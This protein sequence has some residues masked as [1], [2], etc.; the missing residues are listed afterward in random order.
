MPHRFYIYWSKSPSLTTPYNTLP[1]PP[2]H[3]Q[4]AQEIYNCL[5]SH[6][7]KVTSS[8]ALQELPYE[9]SL[10][11]RK[12][13][14]LPTSLPMSST[15][16]LVM[17]ALLPTFYNGQ[18][19]RSLIKRIKKHE[20]HS[21]LDLDHN[22]TEPLTS[23][24]YNLLL[25]TTHGPLDTKKVGQNYHTHNY[26]IQETIRPY[27]TCSNKNERTLDSTV[28]NRQCSQMQ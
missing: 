12:S 25:P 16:F 17:T 11:K 24:T 20:A 15:K 18:S 10:S 3:H 14:L 28:R 6:D 23:P 1:L 5:G 13:H 26:K 19:Y 21:R 2:Y 7:I 22:T 8:S 9:T 4:T 27:R